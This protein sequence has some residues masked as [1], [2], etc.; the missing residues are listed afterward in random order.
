MPTKTSI[1]VEIEKEIQVFRPH[2]QTHWDSVLQEHHNDHNATCPLSTATTTKPT[3][4]ASEA[5]VLGGRR[6]LV[7]GRGSDADVVGGRKIQTCDF[8]P[9]LSA[10][11]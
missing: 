10:I 11:L 7:A 9:V 6:R 4:D 5:G 3:C 1:L 2:L 8:C